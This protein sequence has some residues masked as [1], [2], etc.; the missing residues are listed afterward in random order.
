ML[1]KGG[2]QWKGEVGAGERT[3][4]EMYERGPENPPREGSICERPDNM[5]PQPGRGS[6]LLCGPSQ[7]MEG[8]GP[9]V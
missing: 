4:D 5:A 2:E 6:K 8:K 1:G 9:T 3:T 7:P